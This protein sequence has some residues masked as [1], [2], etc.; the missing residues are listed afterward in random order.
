M[1]GAHVRYT[2]YALEHDDRPINQAAQYECN[3]CGWLATFLHEWQIMTNSEDQI[4]KFTFYFTYS[5]IY[6]FYECEELRVM[7]YMNLS[8]SKFI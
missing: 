1:A 2:T 6:I 7:G 8:V 5:F 3:L 4:W